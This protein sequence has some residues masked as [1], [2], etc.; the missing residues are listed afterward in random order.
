[1]VAHIPSSTSPNY[2]ESFLQTLKNAGGFYNIDPGLFAPAEM[3]VTN[4]STGKV[5]HSGAVD[6]ARLIKA[7]KD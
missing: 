4:L 3:T 7:L 1:V 2:G 6:A 5:F